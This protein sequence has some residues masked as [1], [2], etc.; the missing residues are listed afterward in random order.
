MASSTLEM[1]L[2]GNIIEHDT[3]KLHKLKETKLIVLNSYYK[4]HLNP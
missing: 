4:E 2:N 1:Q 3:F